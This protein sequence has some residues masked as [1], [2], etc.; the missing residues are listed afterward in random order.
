MCQSSTK[1]PLVSTEAKIRIEFKEDSFLIEKKQS[2][3]EF[4]SL[5]Q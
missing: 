3:L 1:F 4:E 2:G 5:G